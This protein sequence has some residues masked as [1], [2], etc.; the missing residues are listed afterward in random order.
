M[1]KCTFCVQRIEFGR[2]AAKDAGRLI[3]DGEVKTA[4]QRA[5]P[6][7]AIGFGNAKDRESQAVKRAQASPARA[8]HAL[9][10]LNTRPGITYLAKVLRGEEGAEG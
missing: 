6:T 9:H 4:C 3:A 8:Y 2:Q 7:D 10:A 5:C 1:E